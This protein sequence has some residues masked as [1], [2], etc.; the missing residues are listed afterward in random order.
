MWLLEGSQPKN[1]GSEESVEASGALLFDSLC[2]GLPVLC[3]VPQCENFWGVFK[4]A[5][6]RMAEWI[7]AR[8]DYESIDGPVRQSMANISCWFASIDWS[9]GHIH[10]LGR[11]LESRSPPIWKANGMVLANLVIVIHRLFA[12]SLCCVHPGHCN[13]QFCYYKGIW[14]DTSF[15]HSDLDI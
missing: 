11:R 4:R 14:W 9:H 7:T 3:S 12:W 8:L 5:E 6:S 1:G 10:N 13:Q 2:S 15:A